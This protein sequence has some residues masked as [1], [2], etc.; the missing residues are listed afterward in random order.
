[1]KREVEMSFEIWVSTYLHGSLA[2]NVFLDLKFPMFEPKLA[3]L[4][5]AILGGGLPIIPIIRRLSSAVA[6]T[7]ANIDPVL[8]LGHHLVHNIVSQKKAT[9]R[10]TIILTGHL[11]EAETPITLGIIITSAHILARLTHSLLSMW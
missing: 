8:V 9:R 6:T 4:G 3:L 7:N 10:N 11:L 1:M 2:L 5:Q